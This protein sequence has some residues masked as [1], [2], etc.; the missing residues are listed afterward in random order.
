[1]TGSA[2]DCLG[3]VRAVNTDARLVQAH[4]ENTDEIVRAWW[5]IVIVFRAHTVIEH[6]FVIAEPRPDVCAENLPRAH[7]SRQSFRPRRNR[8]NTDEPML[9]N[10]CQMVLVCV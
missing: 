6:P 2:A 5:K 10:E 8:K 9:F 4:P 1:M 7:W 3:I